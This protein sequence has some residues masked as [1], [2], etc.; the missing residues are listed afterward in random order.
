MAT[1]VVEFPSEYG[2]ILVEIEGSLGGALPA[3]STGQIAGKASQAFT[4][5]VAGIKP[6]AKAVLAQL[7]DLGPAEAA[8]EFGIKISANA[9]VVLASVASEGHC[10]VKLSWKKSGS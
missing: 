2:P 3:A 4:D 6:I 1:H 7:A 9:G 8:V 5:A 10:L